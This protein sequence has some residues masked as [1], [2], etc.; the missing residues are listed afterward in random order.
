MAEL[1]RTGWTR[2]DDDAAAQ[3]DR[4]W[5]VGNGLGGYASGTVGGLL[6]RRYHGLLIAALPNPWGR[7]MMLDQLQERIAL[8]DAG[9]LDLSPEDAPSGGQS[10]AGPL[11]EFYLDMGLPVW[12]YRV[13]TL[14]VEKR[15]LLSYR[16][17]TVFV[18]YRLLAPGTTADT[19]LQLTLRPAMH[20]RPHD[21]P[22]SQTIDSYT[23]CLT[24]DR[25]E[26][27]TSGPLPSLKMRVEGERPTFRS[28]PTKHEQVS[29]R[30]E[31]ARG[32]EASG[33][34][35]SPGHFEVVLTPRTSAFL[36]ASA[37][38]WETMNAVAPSKAW[39]YETD[40]RNRLLDSAAGARDDTVVAE[41][42]LAADQFVIIPAGRVEDTTR[43]R[44]RG[45]A[46]RSIIAGYHWFT[47][48]GRDTMISLEG[49]TLCAGRY[50]E[51]RYILHTFA[52]YVR[53]G[54]LPNL[55][56]E[57]SREGRYNTADATLWFFHAVDRYLA[58]TDDRET[59]RALLP[60]FEDIAQAHIRGTSF[61]IRVDSADGLL[62]QGQDGVALTWMDALCDG[63]VVTP[64]RGK[65][66]EINALWFNALTLLARWVRS[67]SGETA[68]SYQQMA[69][70]AR[71]SFNRMFW[72]DQ[73][74]Y[75]ADVIS[76]DGK[77][78]E[79]LRPNQILAISLP[80]PVLDRSRWRAVIDRVADRLLTP[81][82]L[83]TLDPGHPDFKPNYHGDLRTRDAAYH[84]GT[85]WSWLL[86]PFIDAWLRVYPE[87]RE[88]AGSL[89]SG[90]LDHLGYAC[91]GQ[92]SEI[93]DASA[94]FLP[95]GCIAQAWG[96]AE[97][98]RAWF[99]THN[100]QP[101]DER[102]VQK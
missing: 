86:G 53:E 39:A 85:V 14:L 63:W 73:R 95:R 56:P 98:L 48:W 93:F 7:T 21:A 34:L 65:A 78:D 1:R 75:L 89:L 58:Y 92:V 32:Y 17:N 55:F 72:S 87:E 74:G 27:S 90:L 49:L 52:H 51:A 100:L 69:D 9:T 47:E 33:S 94:P 64:R 12:R 99:V 91:I 59:L 10:D 41:L 31:A 43:A 18:R 8:P 71:A 97:L 22:V 15:L 68:D 80:N 46:L 54:L 101:R 29:Y 79:S 38:S 11:E 25:F 70:T 16:Q 60:I 20:F 24:G 5:L 26:V 76:A 82:G 66:V 50:R 13:G 57:G 42:V 28:F 96:V 84:Q 83:R 36:V 61:G 44:A 67:E 3:V 6:T 77:I 102:H 30:W 2:R 81:H 88:H 45:E 23:L 37:E 19:S 40:R 4:E 35:W 62:M